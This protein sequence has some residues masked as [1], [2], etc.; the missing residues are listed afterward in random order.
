MLNIIEIVLS[1]LLIG[2]AFIA[3]NTQSLIKSVMLL[4]G[5]S[6]LA[7]VAFVLLKAPDVAVTEA[8][9]GS[10]LVTSLFVFTLLSFRKTG[11]V[12]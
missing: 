6:M 11:D 4:S 8:V 12:Q 7:V 3:L 9:I 1:V 5:I 10:G 2:L